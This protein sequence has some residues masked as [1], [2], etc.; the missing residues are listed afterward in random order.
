MVQNTPVACEDRSH[1]DRL[2]YGWNEP[3]FS[4]ARKEPKAEMTTN[5]DLARS[6]D[7]N[8]CTLS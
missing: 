4:K 6:V 3:R 1:G 2:V 5:C 7:E 8:G